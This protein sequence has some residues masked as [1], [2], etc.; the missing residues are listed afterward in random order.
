M[1]AGIIPAPKLRFLTLTVLA[2][3]STGCTIATGF[4][5]HPT[6]HA[7]VLADAGRRVLEAETRR[8]QTLVPMA[9]TRLVGEN[10]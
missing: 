5:W 2:G 10:A 6:S 9:R 3:L 4:M 1:Q 8:M 7:V